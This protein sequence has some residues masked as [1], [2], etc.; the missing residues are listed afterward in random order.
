MRRPR[1]PRWAAPGLVAGAALAASALALLAGASLACAAGP[2]A[3]SPTPEATRR[4][5]A[6]YGDAWPGLGVAYGPHRDGQRPGGPSPTRDQIR[7]DLALIQTRFGLVRLYASDGPAEAILS[8]IHDEDRP[9]KVLLGAWIAPEDA[10]GARAANAAQVEAA[11]RLANA[12]P[13]IVAGVVVGNETQVEWSAHRLPAKVLLGWLRRARAATALPVGT[14]D[15]FGFWR[16]PESD[17]VAAACDFLVVHAYALWNGRTL[18]DALA[19]TRDRLAEVGRRHPGLPLVLGEAGWATGRADTGEQARLIHGA[20]TEAAQARFFAEWSAWVRRERIVATWFEAF[21]EGWKGG[22][23]PAEV[24][25]HWGLWRA[26]R[27]PKAAVDA[28]PPSP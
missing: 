12:Y 19:F 3:A 20:T 27:S 9:L 5:L 6:L 26:D 23:D 22:D 2:R 4:P 25:K 14:A 24:E 11:V 13:G 7:E 17:A 10:E 28:A 21:D 8:V 18:K 15:D 1:R 16:K